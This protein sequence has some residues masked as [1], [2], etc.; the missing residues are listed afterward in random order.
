MIQSKEIRKRQILKSVR[1]DNRPLS[2]EQRK[3]GRKRCP[4]RRL[5]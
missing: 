2:E 5:E 4:C 1:A 3:A